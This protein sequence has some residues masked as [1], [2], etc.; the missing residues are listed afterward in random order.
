MVDLRDA[1][2]D[3]ISAIRAIYAPAVE[4]GTASFELTPPDAA[5]MAARMH[6]IL[7][8]GYPYRVAVDT[9]AAVVGYAYA[10]AYRPRP[11]YRWTVED[12]VYVHPDHHG[13]GIGR[14]LLT[15]LIERCTERG[16]RRMIAVIGG[17]AAEPSVRLHQAMGFAVCGT[18]PKLGFKHGRWLDSVLMQ[19]GL[20]PGDTTPPDAA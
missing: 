18:I 4:T 6:A 14:Q 16:F 20:G 13:R 3:D 11:A 1:T 19:R 5:E 7:Q 17:D 8:A 12:T 2:P 9:D 10:G 15:D